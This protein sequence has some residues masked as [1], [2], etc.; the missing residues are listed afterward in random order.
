MFTVEWTERSVF[1]LN[2]MYFFYFRGCLQR[3]SAVVTLTVCFSHT[4]RQ[5]RSRF[6]FSQ[7]VQK[8]L[9]KKNLSLSAEVKQVR[10]AAQKHVSRG[11][12]MYSL[13]ELASALISLCHPAQRTRWSPALPPGWREQMNEGQQVLIISSWI[14]LIHKT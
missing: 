5:Q 12:G 7:C 11:S 9:R 4:G 3:S 13:R 6:P 10:H 8:V 1:A 14:I 2:S